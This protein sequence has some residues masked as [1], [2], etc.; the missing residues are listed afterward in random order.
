MINDPAPGYAP[1]WD[2][3]PWVGAWMTTR[4]GGQGQGRFA[5]FNLGDHVGDDPEVVAWHR[6]QLARSVG[7][8]LALLRQVHGHAVCARDACAVDD[9]PEAD[10]QWTS[11]ARAALAIGVADCLPVLWAHRQ[12]PLIAASHAGWRGLAAGVLEDT[13]RHMAQGAGQSLPLCAAQCTV[14]LGPCIGPDAFEVGADVV[15]AFAASTPRQLLPNRWRVAHPDRADRWLVN[16]PALA[17]ARLHAMGV[18]SIHGND[19][20]GA[21][22]TMGNRT[23]YFSHRRDGSP[24]GGTGRML[25]S[26]WLAPSGG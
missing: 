9:Q 1:A 11:Q 15:Q 4:D 23:R 12:T 10:A 16:L 6:A 14:W 8:P 5:G 20:G 2:A 13:L 26:V 17:R 25:A 18:S 24:N 7:R 19:G 3:P 22:C 21:W